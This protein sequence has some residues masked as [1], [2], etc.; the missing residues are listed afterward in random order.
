MAIVA[1]IL[2]ASALIGGLC[3][4]TGIKLFSDTPSTAHVNT[5]V[6]NE[7]AAHVEADNTHE[8]FQNNIISVFIAAVVFGIAIFVLRY[9]VAGIRAV[10]RYNANPNNNNN[11]AINID[12]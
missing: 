5:I 10:R 1:A 9:A 4:Y 3:T 12:V 7:I 11:N 2:G 6:K 8:G